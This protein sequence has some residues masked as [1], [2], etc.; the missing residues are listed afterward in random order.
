MWI[1]GGE[2]FTRLG[3][4]HV[5]CHCLGIAIGGIFVKVVDVL[6]IFLGIVQETY[7][8]PCDVPLHLLL[9]SCVCVCRNRVLRMR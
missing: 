5:P 1:R 3:N 7:K 4:L 6:Q 8:R 2:A 9:F